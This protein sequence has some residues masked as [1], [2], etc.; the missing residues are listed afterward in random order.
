MH[1]FR[2]TQMNIDPCTQVKE[3]SHEEVYD[4]SSTVRTEQQRLLLLG[5][6]GASALLRAAVALE[7]LVL[8]GVELQQHEKRRSEKK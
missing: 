3:G 4:G 8:L 6:H 2:A 1:H 5:G 7:R